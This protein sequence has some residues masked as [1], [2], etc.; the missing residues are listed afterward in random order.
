MTEPSVAGSAT[1]LESFDSDSKLEFIEV[2]LTT[3]D[4]VA[5]P[6]V[7]VRVSVPSVRESFKS[8]T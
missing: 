8:D 1:D 5:P 2:S 4:A 6:A 7:M 3:V